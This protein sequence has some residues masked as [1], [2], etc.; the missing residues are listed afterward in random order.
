MSLGQDDGVRFGVLHNLVGEEHIVDFLCG[1]SLDGHYF[2]V[3]GGL[4]LEVAVLYQYAVQ[5]R[6]EL[7]RGQC[8]LLAGQDDAVLLLTQDFEGV[9]VIV[10]SDD[11]FEEDFRDFL[12]SSLV[13]DGVRDEHT[14]E[15]RY[16]VACQGVLPSLEHRRTGSQT[17]GI[18]VLQDGKRRVIAEFVDEV[19]GSV[20]VQQV[21][22]RDFLA[23]DL[24]E[25][26]V[27]IAV[28]I[29][30]LMGVFAITQG[31]LVVGRVAEG[32]SFA[33]VE[34]VEDGRVV[35]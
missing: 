22:I 25:H 16:G 11:D 5:Q 4:N 32:T 33:A 23:V 29:S 19:Y 8:A 15:S 10:G 18:V 34:V 13:D 26:F 30:L 2:Q 7:L 12:G 27:Q 28:E 1:R 6:T 24:V 9:H 14:T 31:L 35:V 17:T 21:V 20:D 3:F